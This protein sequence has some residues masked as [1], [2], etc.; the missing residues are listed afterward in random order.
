[1]DAHHGVVSVA[2]TVQIL[3]QQVL[4]IVKIL[5]VDRLSQLLILDDV[6]LMPQTRHESFDFICVGETLKNLLLDIDLLLQPQLA[7]S[8]SV[9]SVGVPQLPQHFRVQQLQCLLSQVYEALTIQVSPSVQ[10]ICC[11]EVNALLHHL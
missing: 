6:G 10:V 3:L 1:M 8:E 5:C 4:P 9:L 7:D 11:E 2:D